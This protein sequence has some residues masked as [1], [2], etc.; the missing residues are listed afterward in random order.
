MELPLGWPAIVA[1]VAALLLWISWKF[2]LEPSV[3]PDL[4]IVGY[5]RTQWFAWPRT[6]YKSFHSF[7][8]LYG[9]AFEKVYL[10][11]IFLLVNMELETYCCTI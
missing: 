1:P 2:F 10:F 3:L 4:P 7:R 11:A 8:D 9:E 6:L 5:D